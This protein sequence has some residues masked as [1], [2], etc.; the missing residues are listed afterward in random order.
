M[1]LDPGYIHLDRLR[2][3][4]NIWMDSLAA[5][6]DLSMRRRIAKVSYC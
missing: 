5:I 6:S 4:E 1:L 2:V 3:K